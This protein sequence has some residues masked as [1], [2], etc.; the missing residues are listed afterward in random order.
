MLHWFNQ[1]T[2]SVKEPAILSLPMALFAVTSWWIT[3]LDRLA[4]FIMLLMIASLLGCLMD[5]V[6]TKRREQWN[7]L[8]DD[9]HRFYGD[10]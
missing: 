10:K 3:P 6:D 9:I 4:L 8:R 7:A 2:W 5:Y 1:R